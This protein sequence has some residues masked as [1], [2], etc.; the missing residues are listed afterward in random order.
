MVLALGQAQAPI[1]WRMHHCAPI[2]AA[3]TIETSGSNHSR[4]NLL[5][6]FAC[7]TAIAL[8]CGDRSRRGWRLATVLLSTLTSQNLITVN[9]RKGRRHMT[10]GLLLLLALVLVLCSLSSSLFCRP[11]YYN[12]GASSSSSTA[13]MAKLVVVDTRFMPRRQLL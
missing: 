9:R 4:S 10:H 7:L 2:F 13:Q 12:S 5:L 8:A 11:Y 1:S 6:I 3:V